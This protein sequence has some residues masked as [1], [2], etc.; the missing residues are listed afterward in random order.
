VSTAASPAASLA[1]CD[2]ACALLYATGCWAFC[3]F[4]TGW[5]SVVC[6]IVYCGLAG[7]WVYSTICA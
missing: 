5:A 4:V 1:T 2:Y 3:F 7:T 6:G